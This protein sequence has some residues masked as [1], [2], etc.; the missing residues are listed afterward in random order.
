MTNAENAWRALAA[1]ITSQAP[2]RV[3]L[4]TKG[5]AGG[6]VQGSPIC[7]ER[8]PAG[9]GKGEDWIVILATHGDDDVRVELSRVARIEVPL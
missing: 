2:V 7:L 3:R 8:V 1:L 6:G 5:P 9:D 4:V